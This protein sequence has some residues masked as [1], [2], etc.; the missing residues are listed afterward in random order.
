MGTAAGIILLTDEAGVS[1][2]AE[3]P[4]VALANLCGVVTESEQSDLDSCFPGSLKFLL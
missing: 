2:L 1:T 3:H 4:S